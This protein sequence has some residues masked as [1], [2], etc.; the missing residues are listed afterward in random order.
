MTPD[1]VYVFDIETNGLQDTVT[2]IHSLVIRQVSTGKVWSYSDNDFPGRAGS[3]EDGARHLAALPIIVGHNALTFDISVLERFTSFRLQPTQLLRDTLVL[4][5]VI[6]S[7]LKERDND[8]LRRGFPGYL[9]GSHSLKAWGLRIGVHKG[10][11]PDLNKWDEWSPEMQQ[12]CE[13]D[14]EVTA[15]LWQKLVAHD[16]DPRAANLEHEFAHLIDR[17][18]LHGVRIDEKALAAL[19][20]ELVGE[21][22]RLRAE[23]ENMFP[24]TIEEGKMPQYWAIFLN[25]IE[26]ARHSTKA[27]ATKFAKLVGG[28]VV[29]GPNRVKTYPFNPGSRDEIAARLKEKYGWQSPKKTETG[30]PQIT[31]EI[32]EGL[33]FIEAPQLAKFFAVQKQ[34]GKVAEGDKSVAHFLEAG[35]L[36]PEVNPC[37]AVTGRCTHFKPNVNLKRVQ[38]ADGKPVLGYDGGWGWEL[39]STFTAD[40]GWVLVGADA[41]GIELR[42]LAHYLFPLDGGKYAETI[43]KGDIHMLNTIA[44]GLEPTKSNRNEISKT[45]IYAYAYGAGNWKLGMIYYRKGPVPEA[46]IA[47]M[48][49][50]RK[51][52]ENAKKNKWLIEQGLTSDADLARTVRGQLLRTTFEEKTEGLRELRNGIASA[53]RDRGWL[54]GLDGRRLRVRSQHSA[55]NTLLQSAGG[56]A[57]KKASVINYRGLESQG[58]LFGRDW[59]Q[60]LHVHDEMQNTAR[61]EIAEVVGQSA[62][63]SIKEAGEFF[64]LRIPLDGEYKI[65]RNWAE[66]H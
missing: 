32:L 50:H 66:T 64:S 17:Q 56:L 59:A 55:L 61:P 18:I 42:M 22:E 45:F 20:A 16:L 14:C 48:R 44:L 25:G 63:K 19:Q 24:P 46:E 51:L 2:K 15:V 33:P 7:D 57:V 47:E 21:R 36:H 3:I 41:A 9:M 53:V 1:D 65:G 4:T 31:D 35:R 30:K 60:V 26:H 37:G 52:W 12:Y 23:L 39:R 38:V 49:K 13:R 62:V 28:E 43:L 5:R 54:R 6:W 34:L 29:R 40:D 58:L 11:F 8:L 10:D 27:E